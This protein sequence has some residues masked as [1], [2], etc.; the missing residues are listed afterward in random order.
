[1]QS[2]IHGGKIVVANAI[3]PSQSTIIITIAIIIIIIIMSKEFATHGK[4]RT[5]A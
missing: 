4:D 3:S 5:A 1:M 2:Y